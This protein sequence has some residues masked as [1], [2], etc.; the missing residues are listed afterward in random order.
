MNDGFADRDVVQWYVMR[1]TYCREL[2]AKA[3]LEDSGVECYVPMKRECSERGV[4]VVPAIHNL[5]FV[6]SDRKTMDEW[7][8]KMEECCPLRYAMDKSLGKPMVVRD[9]EMHDFMLVAKKPHDGL[10]YLDDPTVV[11]K[12]GLDVEIVAGPYMGVHG[13]VLR[14]RRDRK[15]VVTIS[16]VLAVAISGLPAEWLKINN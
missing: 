14:I 2:K 8:K 10:L 16:D 11:L 3:L 5:I 4:A 6:R 7:K 12:K 1:A 15:V 13:K 9:R